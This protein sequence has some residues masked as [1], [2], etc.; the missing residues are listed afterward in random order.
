[1]RAGAAGTVFVMAATNSPTFNRA[2]CKGIRLLLLLAIVV[3][4]RGEL[5]TLR[6]PPARLPLTRREPSSRYMAG[7]RDGEIASSVI[8]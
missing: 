2:N 6:H 5:F 7:A 8:I 3:V 1:M 4:G